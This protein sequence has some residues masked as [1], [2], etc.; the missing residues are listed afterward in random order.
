MA[1]FEA[2]E[3]PEDD[4]HGDHSEDDLQQR[5]DPECG[6]RIDQTFTGA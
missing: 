2:I 5:F 4:Q 3:K 1:G 6:A